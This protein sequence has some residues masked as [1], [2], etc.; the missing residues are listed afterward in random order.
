ME[1]VQ[2]C[3]YSIKDLL[4]V[5]NILRSP[6]GCPWDRVQTHSSIRLRLIEESYEAIEAIDMSNS[7]MLREELGDI[8]L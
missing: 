7:D 4:N 8:L 3:K 5:V 6:K 2:K 1:L